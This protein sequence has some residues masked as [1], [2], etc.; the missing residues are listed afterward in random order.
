MGQTKAQRIVKQLAGSVQKQTAIATDMFIPNHSGDNSAGDVLKTPTKDTDI[1]NKKY[2]DDQTTPVEWSAT[3]ISVVTGTYVS[4]DVTDI[5]TKGDGNTYDVDEVTG[6]PGFNILVTFT[7]VTHFNAIK[8][9]QKYDGHI[10]HE[11][12]IELYNY[13][14]TNWDCFG[15]VTPSLV[16]T[17][18]DIGDINDANYVSG[19][20]VKLRY[21]HSTAGNASDDIH[22]DYTSI[23]A[24]K[25]GSTTPSLWEQGDNGT[26][27]VTARDIDMQTKKIINLVDPTANQEAATKKYVDDNDVDGMW[28]SPASGWICPNNSC[29]VCAPLICADCLVSSCGFF[30]YIC[31]QSQGCL[32]MCTCLIDCNGSE[33]LGGGGSSLWYDGGGYICNCNACPVCI[34]GDYAP[35]S[36][37]SSYGCQAQME[38]GVYSCGY[39]GCDCCIS[40]N[41]GSNYMCFCGG[42]FVYAA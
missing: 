25:G 5:R 28:N 6:V 1:P 17:A 37:Y 20:E 8:T 31:S 32:C 29:C 40:Y 26:E 3:S 21:Y 34:C 41:G 15:H 42:V 10:S 18:K 35:M 22:I 7:G 14:T 36:V 11:V 9:Q 38:N 39:C 12:C 4:G 13:A 23:W 24:S 19:G 33:I 30:N 27:L 16:Q 2:V